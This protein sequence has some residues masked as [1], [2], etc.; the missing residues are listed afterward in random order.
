M[1]GLSKHEGECG[2]YVSDLLGFFQRRA[3]ATGY[4]FPRTS[5]S[6]WSTIS[7]AVPR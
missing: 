4:P 1:L 5:A 2:P 6:T 3:D 7:R